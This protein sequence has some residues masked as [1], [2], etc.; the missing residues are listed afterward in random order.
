[1]IEIICQGESPSEA[2]AKG[3]VAGILLAEKI[4]TDTV[5]NILNAIGGIYIA[6]NEG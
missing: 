5:I 2:K 6:E 4:S 3:M 1:M